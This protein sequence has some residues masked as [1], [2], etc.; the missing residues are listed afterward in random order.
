MKIR[1]VLPAT[2]ALTAS[3]FLA[4]PAFA[5]EAIERDINICKH[6]TPAPKDEVI[7]A[8]RHRVNIF[9]PEWSPGLKAGALNDLGVAF[10]QAGRY[11]D[12][13]R[14]FG[15]GIRDA[16]L[17]DDP[18]GTAL[19]IMLRGNRA[20]AFR[21]AKQWDRALEDDDVLVAKRPNSEHYAD[22]CLTRVKWGQQLDLALADC[23]QAVQLDPT[24]EKA[25]SA[26][27]ILATSFKDYSRALMDYDA[28]VRLHRTFVNLN[29]RCWT[30]LA[31]GRE[32]DLALADCDEAVRLDPTNELALKGHLTAALRLKDYPRALLDYDALVRIKSTPERLNSR[33]WTRAVWN[34]QLELAL[35]DCNA[36]IQQNAGNANALDSRG[37]VH[38]RMANYAAAFKD[39]DAAVAIN[40]KLASSLYVRGLAKLKLGDASG[41]ADI[42]AAEAL[43]PKIADKYAGYGVKP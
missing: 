19:E 14:A 31:A 23:G 9:P 42:E 25:L 40:P 34:K 15:D 36:A 35:A 16:K 1:R 20:V 13:A 7:E 38:F 30:R 3:L 27:A 6:I 43:D 37:F 41:N 29:A 17:V 8:C 33:C 22:R 12:A 39:Y 32:F 2:A 5:S 10:L 4:L 11:D 18:S 28:L 24:N 21:F 26:H